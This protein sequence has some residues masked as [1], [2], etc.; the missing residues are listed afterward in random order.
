[1]IV[2]SR[3]ISASFRPSMTVVM[4]TQFPSLSVMNSYIHH[5]LLPA[6]CRAAR[7]LLKW[8][9]PELSKRSNVSVVTISIFENAKALPHKSTVQLLM[10]VFEVAGVEFTNGDTSRVRLGK[11]RVKLMSWRFDPVHMI[12]VVHVC[13][14]GRKI[15]CAFVPK[16][17]EDRDRKSYHDRKEFERAF[18][19]HDHVG[20]L[21]AARN[22][23]DA[24]REHGGMIWLNDEDFPRNW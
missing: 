18:G 4:K 3:L 17:L 9:Q 22:A 15:E 19:M 13:D 12:F 2:G 8:T 7:G 23:V 24:G 5:M 10:M 6:Q 1:M 21:V 14:G 16:I 20:I 11:P